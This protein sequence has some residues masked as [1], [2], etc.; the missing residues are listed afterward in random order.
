MYI[1]HVHVHVK[2]DQVEAFIIATKENAGKSAGNEPG[3]ARFDV[4][5]Q[6]DDPTRFVL[7]EV[8][9][10]PEDAA[11][12]K[13]TNHY[14]CWREIAEPMMVEPRKRFVYQNI[15]PS[16]LGYSVSMCD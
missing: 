7:I 13:G 2:H 11:R 4:M 8:Y 3:V 5:Q 1:V 12:H 16:D 9:R 6:V 10:T 14:N 15:F